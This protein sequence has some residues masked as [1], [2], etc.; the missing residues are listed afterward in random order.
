MSELNLGIVKWFSGQ[1]GYGFI[2]KTDGRDIFVHYSGIEMEGYKT[3]K[4][5]DEVSFEIGDS[6]KGPIAVNVKVTKAS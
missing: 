4:E 2:T 5:N 1:K 3:L 6:D